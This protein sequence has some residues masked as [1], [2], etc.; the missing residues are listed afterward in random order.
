VNLAEA[1]ADYQARTGKASDIARQL[2]F[3]G[4]AFVWVFSGGNATHTGRLHIPNNLLVVGLVLVA[5]LACDLLQYVYSGAAVGILRWVEERKL[6]A[7]A[8][9]SVNVT[10]DTGD[11]KMPAQANWATVALYW[12]KIASIITAYVLLGVALESRI[13]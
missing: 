10:P 4:I 12:S 8:G 9:D 7:A 2:A 1:K 6:Q 3:A 11:F 13:H 5:G